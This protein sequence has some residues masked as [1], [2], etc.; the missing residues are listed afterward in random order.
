MLRVIPLCLLLIGLPSCSMKTNKEK[1]LRSD[2][3]IQTVKIAS[4]NVSFAHDGDPTE[5]F[6]QWVSFMNTPLDEQE[7][8]IKKWK[9]GKQ[10]DSERKLSERIMQIRNDA[11]TF[12]NIRV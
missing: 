12:E 5:N 3:P 7:V 2:E 6:E 11:H 1:S 10:S 9:L 4:F 8:L